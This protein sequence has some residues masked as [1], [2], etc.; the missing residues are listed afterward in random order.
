MGAHTADTPS[1]Q[2]ISCI[3]S[4]DP[5]MRFLRLPVTEQF[6]II[7]VDNR[8]YDIIVETI[9]LRLSRNPTAYNR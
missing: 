7:D 9:V 6:I 2:R 1:K 5:S 3:F 4:A 8:S